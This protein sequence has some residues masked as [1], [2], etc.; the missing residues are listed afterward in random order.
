MAG[1]GRGKPRN[2]PL[3]IWGAS[4]QAKVLHEFLAHSGFDLVAIFDNQSAARS[5]ISGIP[6][7]IGLQTFKQWRET[8]KERGL[9]G[10]VAIGSPGQARLEIQ[11]LFD[12][13]GVEVISAIHPT[14]FVAPTSRLGR[15]CQVLAHAVVAADAALGDQC[16]I[17]TAASV[18]HEAAL[19]KGVHVAPGARVLGC[20]QIGEYSFIGAGSVILSRLQVGRNSIIGAGSVVTKKIADNVVA[21]GSPAKVHRKVSAFARPA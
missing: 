16:I 6:I 4:G 21:Y 1:K 10:V 12:Q 14:A 3:I 7:H 13:N 18:D 17:N 8:F 2:R 5:P 19:E 20:V 11:S 15:G 9:A